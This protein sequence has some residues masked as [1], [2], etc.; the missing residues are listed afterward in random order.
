M[1]PLKILGK[2]CRLRT[3]NHHYCVSSLYLYIV[4][5]HDKIY[6]YKD[7]LISSICSYY[8]GRYAKFFVYLKSI[9]NAGRQ[10]F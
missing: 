5:L 3:G 2:E 10:I 9:Y 8:D 1:P 7:V 6:L 4:D